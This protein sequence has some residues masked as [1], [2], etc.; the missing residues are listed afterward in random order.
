MYFFLVF[1]LVFTLA[2]VYYFVTSGKYCKHL[3]YADLS[4]DGSGRVKTE[5]GTNHTVFD[6]NQEGCKNR[7]N[8]SK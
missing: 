2:D 6:K 3:C 5:A 4:K 1:S 7:E 8:N